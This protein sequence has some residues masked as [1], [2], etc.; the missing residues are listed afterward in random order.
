[1]TAAFIGN[2]DLEIGEPE[3]GMQLPGVPVAGSS[4]YITGASCSGKRKA[5]FRIT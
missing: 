4:S 1:M 5:V 3:G 2:A